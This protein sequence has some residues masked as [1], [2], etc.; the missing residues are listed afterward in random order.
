MTI[1]I[2]KLT[3]NTVIDATYICLVLVLILILAVNP[4]VPYRTDKPSF[5]QRSLYTSV[6]FKFQKWIWNLS[7]QLHC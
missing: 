2:T 4:L 5:K 1:I 7:H 6:L 3:K